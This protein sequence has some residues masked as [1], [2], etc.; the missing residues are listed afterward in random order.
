ML[1]RPP[2][3]RSDATPIF[4]HKDD[5]AWD[6]ERIEAEKAK[7]DKPEM[8]PVTRYL[9]GWGRYDLDARGTVDGQDVSAREYLDESKHPTMFRFRRMTGLEWY[10]A[11]AMW[12]KGATDEAFL[13]AVYLTLEKIENGPELSARPGGRLTAADI[14]MLTALGHEQEPAIEL[15]YLLGE[16]GYT[17]SMPLTESEK[18][19]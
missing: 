7:M 1:K 18:K 14:D 16:V 5:P 13:R 11:H 15:V 12:K 17:A 2:Q 9:G 6:H 3:H 4:V 10:E 19:P 8:H